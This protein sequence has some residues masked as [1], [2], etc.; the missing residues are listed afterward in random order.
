MTPYT[1]LA[2]SGER[3]VLDEISAALEAGYGLRRAG[4]GAEVLKTAL[5]PSPADLILL[6]AVLPDTDGFAVL[7]AL[8]TNPA[9]VN[10][11]VIVLSGPRDAGG[12]ERG[13]LLGAADC[14]AK[15]LNGALVRARVKT[16]ITLAEQDRAIKK[17]SLPDSLSGMPGRRIFDERLGIEWKRAIRE[18]TAVSLLLVE[19][20]GDGFIKQ[21]GEILRANARRP[22]DLAAR[23]DSG[24]FAAL[25]PNT[26]I[27]GALKL[28][29]DI[30]ARIETL[31][32]K[33][34]EN[35]GPAGIGAVSRIPRADMAVEDFLAGAEKALA[36]SKA[37]GL[38]C[39]DQA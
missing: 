20:P 4:S 24:I 26:G 8:K 36:R 7:V 30:R 22:S 31:S 32:G 17:N 21:A 34:A 13:L 6:D 29:E 38:I 14:I 39:R 33:G 28:A 3:S 25:L 16:H 12:E 37:S 11:P 18:K 1:I 5:E 35:A 15:P 10:I 9:A 23:L 27:D 2:A 19:V